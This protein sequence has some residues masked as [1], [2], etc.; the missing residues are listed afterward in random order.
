MAAIFI[1]TYLQQ[2]Y[3]SAKVETIPY[4]QFKQHIAEGKLDKLTI[5]P[6]N[7][8]GTLEGK[9]AQ[10]FTTLREVVLSTPEKAQKLGSRIPKGVLLVGPPGGAG[11]RREL[12]TEAIFHVGSGH[13]G[14]GCAGRVKEMYM[15]SNL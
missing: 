12:H 13:H 9:P 11:R 2:C 1:F 4:S 8:N 3:F 10:E 5:G 6:E 7:I 14:A 15:T